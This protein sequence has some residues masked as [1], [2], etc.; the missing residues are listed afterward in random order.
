MAVPCSAY[1]SA[2]QSLE[3]EVQNLM[4]QAKSDPKLSVE[5]EQEIREARQ[6]IVGLKALLAKC[7]KRTSA[8][9]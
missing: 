1:S 8:K 9:P 6:A 5:I 2:I 4:A 7:Q 3:N